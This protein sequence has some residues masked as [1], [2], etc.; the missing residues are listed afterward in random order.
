[1]TANKQMIREQDL[2]EQIRKLVIQYNA[3]RN[4]IVKP[5]WTAEPKGGRL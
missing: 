2:H 5:P 1:M 3:D 4:T